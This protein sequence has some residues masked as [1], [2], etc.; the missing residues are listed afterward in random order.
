MNAAAVDRADQ[1][2]EKVDRVAQLR[3]RIRALEA[4]PRQLLSVVRTGVAA[5]D[6][7]LPQGGLPLGQ[8]VE[9][10][11]EAASGRTSLALRAAASAQ[12]AG[13]LCAWV[14]GP[15]ELYPP[16]AAALGVDLSALLMVR[17]RAPGQLVWAAQQLARSGAFACVVLD[18]TH[19]GVRLGLA[20]GKKLADAAVA[21]GTL[22]ILLT[23]RD[24]PADGMLRLGTA[25][26]GPEGFTVEVLRSRSGG[27]HRAA[28]IPW[29]ALWEQGS[30]TDEAGERAPEIAPDAAPP[31]GPEGLLEVGYR[32]RAPGRSRPC[33][34]IRGQRPGRD[35][36]IPA[37]LHGALAGQPA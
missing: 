33:L 29:T 24:A 10:W 23:P 2:A 13:R 18:V 34:G 3:E 5:F 12:R 31:A 17:P 4:A 35:V 22:L 26:S 15:A 16:T 9:L 37:G 36:R 21:S 28:E 32:R 8:A 20:E 6:G 1:A 7:L 25:A 11:G 19:T 30:G 14:D 27:L